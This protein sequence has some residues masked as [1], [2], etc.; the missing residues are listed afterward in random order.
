MRLVEKAIIAQKFGG[1]SVA[2]PER[3]QMVVGHVRRE[4]EAGNQV[5]LV[6]SATGR[7]GDPYATDT[8][9]DLLRNMGGTI[10]PRNYAFLFVTGEMI[11]VA[12]MVHTLQRA[13]IPA[14]ALTGGMAG[15]TTDDFYMSAHVVATDNRALCHYLQ[16]GIVPIVCG[17]QGLSQ[18]NSDFSILGRDSSDTSGVL[19]GIMV[20]AERADIYTDV[21][22][23]HAVDPI[24][25]PN[26]P[27]RRYI[28][29]AAAYEMA[30]FGTKVI[31]TGAVQLGMEHHLPIRVRSTFSQDPGTLI[32]AEEDH[33]RLVG[34]PLVA[35]T[36]VAVLGGQ[37]LDPVGQLSLERHVGLVRLVDASSGDIVL[38]APLGDTVSMVDMELSV[39]GV[40]A[41]TWQRGYSLLSLIGK[42]MALA[43]MQARA[44]L[45]L[46]RKGIDSP[47]REVTDCRATFVVPEQQST[48]ALLAVYGELRE[49]LD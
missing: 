21:E 19:V 35:S 44:A 4:L 39:S 15:I 13:G 36:Q 23:V 30:R 9:L 46:R 27:A 8:I 37:D 26:A 31:K 49:Y 43:E 22:Y 45:V 33:F 40:T 6:V 20:N 12:I 5:A 3:R 24:I 28:S 2:T 7:R 38:C 29:Y 17:G 47:Y 42:K 10:D 41:P 18:T 1:T 14:V 48:A 11:S 16:Q 34:L 32:G 25:V